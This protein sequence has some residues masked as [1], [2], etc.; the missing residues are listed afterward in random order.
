MLIYATIIWEPGHVKVDSFI[1]QFPVLSDNSVKSKDAI[2]VNFIILCMLWHV[3]KADLE[4]YKI[5][6][7]GNLMV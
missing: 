4:E 5:K 6:D 2:Y 7:L 3:M 1:I